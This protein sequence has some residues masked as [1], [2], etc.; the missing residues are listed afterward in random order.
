MQPFASIADLGRGLARGDYSARELATFHLERIAAAD[1]DLNAFIHVTQE[2]ALRAADAADRRIARGEG[3]PLTGIP[4]AHKDIFCTEGVATTCASRMLAD[5]VP[6]YDATVVARLAAAGTVCLGKTNMD[7]FAMGSSSETSWFGPARNP[8]DRD[9][10]PGGSS[11]GSAAAVGAGLVPCAT[12][13]DTGG[14]IRQPAA[15]CGVTGLK[16][17]Y[18]RVSRY[19]MIAFASSL[20]QG[21]AFGL[22]VEDVETVLGAM[23]GH[24][25]LDST[26]A[27]RAPTRRNGARSMRIGLPSEYWTGLAGDMGECL[28]AAAKELEAAGHALVSHSLPHTDAAVPAYYVIAGAEASANLSRYDGVRFGFRAEDPAD[29]DDLYRRSRAAGFGTEVKRRI[30]TGTYTLSVGYYDA[31][32]LK[33]Q[34]VRRRIQQD[35][36]EAFEEVDAIAA[37]VAPG[38]AFELGAVD[39]P[40]AMY[41]QDVFTTPASLAG[42]PAMSMPCGFVGGLP[43]GLQLIGPAFEEGR[44][45]ALGHE[46]QRRTDWHRRH[47]EG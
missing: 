46:F 38:P 27:E 42:L 3:G 16:P 39:D 41:R 12:G 14:S 9:R 18:G 11:G 24:D 4:L 37:P 6:P 25:P 36:L 31:Y 34:R 23:E 26:S 1:D 22:S 44:L 21:G 10:A 35:F 32:Y 17:T 7:E 45:L 30:L 43:V 29:L 15:F 20:D 19:G 13:T 40:V 28:L 8:W 5:F 2:R 33:A 47:P